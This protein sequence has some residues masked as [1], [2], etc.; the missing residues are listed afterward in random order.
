MILRA[1]LRNGIFLHYFYCR[2]GFTKRLKIPTNEF[3]I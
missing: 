3:D 1:N 2:Q